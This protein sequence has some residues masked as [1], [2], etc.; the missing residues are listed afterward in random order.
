MRKLHPSAERLP[1][2]LGP[3]TWRGEARGAELISTHD[4]ASEAAVGAHVGFGANFGRRLESTDDRG[5]PGYAYPITGRVL[6]K[7][8]RA[9]AR[10]KAQNGKMR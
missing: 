4:A 1:L 7:S 9:L 2:G 3:R 5:V 6:A 8:K 10:I